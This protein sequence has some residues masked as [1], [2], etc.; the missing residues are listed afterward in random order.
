MEESNY[1]AELAA[2]AEVVVGQ[3]S[4]DAVVIADAILCGLSQVADAIRE[5]AEVE[6][7]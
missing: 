2:R 7:E 3:A 1:I 5:A 4:P 6:P